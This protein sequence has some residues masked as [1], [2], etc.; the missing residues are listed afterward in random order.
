MEKIIEG[1]I[2]LLIMTRFKLTPDGPEELAAVLQRRGEFN[3]KTMGPKSWPGAYQ[4]TVHGKVEPN[5]TV[6]DA[7]YRETQEELGENYIGS[8][9]AWT[10]TMFSMV[11]IGKVEKPGKLIVHYAVEI[12]PD[13]L[14]LIRLNAST[15]GLRL[16]TESDLKDLQP[17]PNFNCNKTEGVFARRTIAMFPD[18]IPSLKRAFEIFGKLPVP[19]AEVSEEAL[20]AE[21]LR[22]MNGGS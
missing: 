14:K 22:K 8:L 17:A 13:R 16:V 5:E 18:E 19:C 3:H 20:H 11:Q 7:L 15:G 4:L 12:L 10:E 21:H 6:L 9:L 2:S 1:S